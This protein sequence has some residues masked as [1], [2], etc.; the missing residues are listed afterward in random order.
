MLAAFRLLCDSHA[1]PMPEPDFREEMM[2]PSAMTSDSNALEPYFFQAQTESIAGLMLIGLSGGSA[3]RAVEPA[4]GMRHEVHK[5]KKHQ[6]TRIGR[7]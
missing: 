7:Q 4:R 2:T 1:M 3:A 5:R 6:E